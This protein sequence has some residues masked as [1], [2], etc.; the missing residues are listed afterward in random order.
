MVRQLDSRRVLAAATLAAACSLC[1]ACG[2]KSEDGVSPATVPVD[3]AAAEEEYDWEYLPGEEE[4]VLECAS[5]KLGYVLT[6]EFMA[7]TAD[8]VPEDEVDTEEEWERERWMRAHEQCIFELPVAAADL[9]DP[10]W[11]IAYRHAYALDENGNPVLADPL[12][13]WPGE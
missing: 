4:A 5:E 11:Y 13:P 2:T 10:G 12:A 3:A 1:A 7:E 6:P 9:D 8:L